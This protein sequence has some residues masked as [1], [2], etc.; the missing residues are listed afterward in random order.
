MPSFYTTYSDPT[1]HIILSTGASQKAVGVVLQQWI[2]DLITAI[3]FR[4]KRL[5]PT[6]ERYS[7]FGLELLTIYLA[8]RHFNFL[9][10]RRKFTVKLLVIFLPRHTTDT[11]HDNWIIFHNLQQTSSS[12]KDISTS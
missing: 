2:N 6:Q 1:T 8:V 9:L 10:Q 7:T 12:L 11:H 3:A 5:S 4:S